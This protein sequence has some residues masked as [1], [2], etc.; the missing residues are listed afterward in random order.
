MYSRVARQK[1]NFSESEVRKR[2]SFAEGY[3][4]WDKENWDNVLFSD[5]KCFFGAGFCGKTWVI[6]P[7]G[8]EWNP[9]YVVHKKAHPV[10]MNAWACFSSSGVGFIFLFSGIMDADVMKK[11]LKENLVRSAD[12]LFT[13]AGQWWLL[14]D[15]DKKFKSKKVSEW[16]HN[17]Y[18]FRISTIFS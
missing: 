6:R 18:M 12:K 8:E 17:N 5:E 3:S 16:L 1:R 7:K 11:T 15:N 13:S 14:H 9:D 4:S 2:L 10:K